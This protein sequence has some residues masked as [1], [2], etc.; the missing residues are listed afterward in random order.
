MKGYLNSPTTVEH[1]MRSLEAALSSYPTH[2]VTEFFLSEVFD[3]NE[4]RARSP[5]MRAAKK[6]EIK[7]LLGGRTFEVVLRVDIS[8]DGTCY[9]D[10]LH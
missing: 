3:K 2:T 6:S 1:H 4:P 10:V 8:K 5:R 7:N 9:R